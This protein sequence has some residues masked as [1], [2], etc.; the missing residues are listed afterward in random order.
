MSDGDGCVHCGKSFKS[1]VEMTCEHPLCLNCEDDIKK[2]NEDAHAEE[3]HCPECNKGVVHQGKKKGGAKKDSGQDEMV[4]RRE[5]YRKNRT[6]II[7]NLE[8]L[9]RENLK[10]DEFMRK[11]NVIGEKTKGN[12]AQMKNTI[13]KECEALVLII[14]RRK[15]VM[16]AKVD[17]AQQDKLRAIQT[18]MRTCQKSISKGHAII[19]RTNR[20]LERMPQIT[21]NS[22]ADSINGSINDAKESH[23]ELTPCEDEKI[24]YKLDTASAKEQCEQLDL[25][26]VEDDEEEGEGG[27]KE[28]GDKEKEEENKEEGEKKEGEENEEEKEGGGAWTEV[29]EENS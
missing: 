24:R 2:K 8:E 1:P 21:L 26:E 6:E 20:D 25:E 17:K 22:K 14:E 29:A 10:V 5:L 18:Q 7:K 13:I 28:D 4:E 12:A 19:V 16:L 23:P 11:L 9:E 15:K 3:F 27:G